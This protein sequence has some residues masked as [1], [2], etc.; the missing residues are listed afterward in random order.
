MIENASEKAAQLD[1]E[2]PLKYTQEYFQKTGDGNQIYF[3]GNS[4][5]LPSKFVKDT[6]KK[7]VDTWTELYVYILALTQDWQRKHCIV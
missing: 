2:D 7:H 5:G 3:C 6:I 1:K 4:L